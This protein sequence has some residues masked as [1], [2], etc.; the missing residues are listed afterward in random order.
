MDTVKA[1]FGIIMLG[2]AIMMLDR[3]VSRE[4]T[5]VSTGILLVASGVYMGA[6]DKINHDVGGWGR[7]WK[8]LGMIQLFYGALLLFGVA[9]GSQNLW[10]PLKGVFGSSPS[11]NSITLQAPQTSKL[12]FKP[13]HSMADLNNA[14]EEAKKRTIENGA[15]YGVV[16][17]IDLFQ[18]VTSAK[19]I[20]HNG[21]SN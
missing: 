14:L 6:L 18:K 15:E 7:F 21:E 11:N 1:V 4:I 2:I 16:G 20:I 12:I 9:A 13:I 8:S 19:S 3:V 10:Q 5:M 17:L